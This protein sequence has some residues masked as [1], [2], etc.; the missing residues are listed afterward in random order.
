MMKIVIN[1]A[2]KK[3]SKKRRKGYNNRRNNKHLINKTIEVMTMTM[4]KTAKMI[5]GLE[6]KEVVVVEE[7]EDQIIIKIISQKVPI[8]TKRN[9]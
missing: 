1:N 2:D 5:K 3:L 7:E 9:M 8:P 4:I 6:A